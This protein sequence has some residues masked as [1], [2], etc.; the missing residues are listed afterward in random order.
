M[1]ITLTKK[2]LTGALAASLLVLQLPVVAAA[3]SG[4]ALAAR[5]AVEYLKSTQQQDG[6]I[7]PYTEWAVVAIAA[8]GDDPATVAN[9]DISTIDAIK[10]AGPGDTATTLERQI[11]AINAAGLGSADFGGQD[12]NALLSSHH[13]NGQIG[14]LELLND[15]IFGI[16]A[17]AAAKDAGMLAMAQD[18]L[19]YL[20]AN[21][22]SDGGFSYSTL[23]CSWLGCTDS[24]SDMT[25][26]A[27]IAFKAAESL[28]LHHADFGDAHTKA[29]AYLLSTQQS[30]GG[31]GANPFTPSDGSTTA[32]ALMAFNALGD[33]GA[34]HATDATQWLLAHQDTDSSFN[35]YY[36][37]Y[38]FTHDFTAEAVI[39][40]LGTTWLLDPAPMQT[41]PAKSPIIATEPQPTVLVSANAQSSPT[42][43]QTIEPDDVAEPPAVETEPSTQTDK[44][45]VE[46]TTPISE[47]KGLN[48]K[49]L[50]YAA[51][52]LGLVGFGLH[53]TRPKKAA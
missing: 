24:S 45:T 27:L 3:N 18:A 26:A 28:G 11:L 5:N 46:D 53:L 17:I 42:P 13:N 6:N 39:A 31:F 37:D 12:Y 22:E 52:A 44:P 47:A 34:S 14:D 38:N 2:L 25:A 32:W 9:G 16:I 41:P 40:L 19:D 35:L 10:A 50:I 33:T 1:S 48:I 49:Y 36:P 51:V 23:P 7:N 15:D 8:A 29:L 30:D 43:I 4:V 20:I 21:Q